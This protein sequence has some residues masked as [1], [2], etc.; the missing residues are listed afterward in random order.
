VFLEEIV[1]D[2]ASDYPT[3]TLKGI[4]VAATHAGGH[5]EE[6]VDKLPELK[7]VFAPRA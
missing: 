7:V 4:S 5:L 3:V 1:A 6:N 2:P